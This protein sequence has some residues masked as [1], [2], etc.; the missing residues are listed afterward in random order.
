MNEYH[1]ATLT[2][3]NFK[4]STLFFESGENH[5]TYKHTHIIHE[6]STFVKLH[7]TL[8]KSNTLCK[9]TQTITKPHLVGFL[10]NYKHC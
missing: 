1:F 6:M 4:V 10:L 3:Y 8:E 9:R 2:N 5:A 7:E